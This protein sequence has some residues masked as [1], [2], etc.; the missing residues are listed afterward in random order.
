MVNDM[1]N[2]LAYLMALRDEPYEQ[3]HESLLAFSGVGPKVADCVCLMSLDKHNC[4]PVDTHVWQI[5][6]RDYKL[7]AK[8]NPKGHKQ[9]QAY[10]QE[11]W[12]DYAG[13]AHSVLFAGDL[14]DLNNGINVDSAPLVAPKDSESELKEDPEKLTHPIKI[15]S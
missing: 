14:S 12:G 3:A 2:G 15:E 6:S 13:W 11:L 10:F 7:K 1:P 4:V 5:A 8:N 9:I